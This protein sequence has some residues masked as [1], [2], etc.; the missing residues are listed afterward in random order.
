MIQ[1]KKL[2]FIA[3]SFTSIH[4]PSCFYD[5][6][7]SQNTIDKYGQSFNKAREIIGLTPLTDEFKMIEITPTSPKENYGCIIWEKSRTESSES[8][9]KRIEIRNDTI[10]SESDTYQSKELYNTIDGHLNATL[11]ISYHF[12]KK[13]CLQY[14]YNGFFVDSTSK[15]RTLLGISVEEIEKVK[16]DSIIKS[17]GY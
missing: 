1:L 15:E 5:N 4:F 10:F 16:A 9:C 8:I 14:E 2:L 12:D 7:L 17:W 3:L 11:K 6:R 13:K